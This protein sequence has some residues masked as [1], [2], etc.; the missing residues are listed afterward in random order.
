MEAFVKDEATKMNLVEK[1]IAFAF[2]APIGA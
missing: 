1:A 2:I